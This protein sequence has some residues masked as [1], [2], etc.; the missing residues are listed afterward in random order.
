MKTKN[1]KISYGTKDILQPGDLNPTHIKE[2]ITIW[3][4][5]DIVDEFR[6]RATHVP[7]GKYQ[8]LI[9][10]ALREYLKNNY[11]NVQNL[12]FKDAVREIVREEL[13]KKA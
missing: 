4:D 13:R 10:D 6:E 8:R 2:K 11:S 12:S 1:K 7:G 3:L 5:Q 9:N